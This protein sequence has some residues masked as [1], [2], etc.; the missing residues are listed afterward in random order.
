MVKGWRAVATDAL[1]VTGSKS[2][3]GRPVLRRAGLRNILDFERRTDRGSNPCGK[4]RNADRRAG[5]FSWLRVWEFEGLMPFLAKPGRPKTEQRRQ[6][7]ARRGTAHGRGYGREWQSHA[8]RFKLRYPLCGM[9]PNGQ[10]PVMSH[11]FEQGSW[12][13][14]TSYDLHPVILQVVAIKHSYPEPP[15]T[16]IDG[17]NP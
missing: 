2:G 5:R 16:R 1:R 10:A 13:S 3:F 4:R 7:D 6:S 8:A 9:R 14:T 17:Q 12:L 15:R 11:C